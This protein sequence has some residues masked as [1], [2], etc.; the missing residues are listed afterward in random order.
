MNSSEYSLFQSSN[1]T[2]IPEDN[3]E[4]RN[5]ALHITL[6]IIDSNV[7]DHIVFIKYFKICSQ[8]FY[9]FLLLSTI[10]F[11]ELEANI[12]TPVILYILS[13]ISSYVMSLAY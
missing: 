6:N 1:C 11:L 4:T 10:L 3:Y 8:V 12:Y 2:A 5:S 9:S 7:T 13:S